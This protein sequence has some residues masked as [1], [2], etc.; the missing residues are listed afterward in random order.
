MLL[1]FSQASFA[2]TLKQAVGVLLSADFGPIHLLWFLRLY[3]ASVEVIA[4]LFAGLINLFSGCVFLFVRLIVP[5]SSDL[6]PIAT[7]LLF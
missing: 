3:P 7:V 6:V 1:S 5:L 4:F 2:I